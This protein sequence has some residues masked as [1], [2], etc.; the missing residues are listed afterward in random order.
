MY[1][2]YQAYELTYYKLQYHHTR[3]WGI[4]YPKRICTCHMARSN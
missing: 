3:A 2:L 4:S 1:L